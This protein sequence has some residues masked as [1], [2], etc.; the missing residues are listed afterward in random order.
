MDYK[1]KASLMLERNEDE[2]A[3]RLVYPFLVNLLEDKG[4]I[5]EIQECIIDMVR[6]IQDLKHLNQIYSSVELKL[7][8]EKAKEKSQGV[9]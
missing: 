1:K 5:Y 4:S 7:S 6:K 2:R 9:R 3:A 8:K